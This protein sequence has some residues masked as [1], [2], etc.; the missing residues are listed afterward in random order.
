MMGLGGGA[1]QTSIGGQRPAWKLETRV[2]NS[3]EKAWEEIEVLIEESSE[4]RGGLK[5]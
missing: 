4:D 2:S 5:P 3:E 1:L